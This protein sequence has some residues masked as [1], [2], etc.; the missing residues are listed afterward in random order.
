MM[1]TTQPSGA[2][3]ASTAAEGVEATLT[4]PPIPTTS[5][6]SAHRETAVRRGRHRTGERP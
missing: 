5:D 6:V 4:A 1:S 2:T 3:G